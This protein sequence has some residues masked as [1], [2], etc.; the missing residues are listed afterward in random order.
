M[1]T[2][3]SD[4]SSTA[5]G[6]RGRGRQVAGLAMGCVVALA[7]GWIAAYAPGRIKLLGL[8]SLGWGALAGWCLGSL[9]R[10]L[11]IARPRTI[12][13]L[14]ALLI[15]GGFLAY[16]A[17]SYRLYRRN[18]QAQ[19]DRNPASQWKLEEQV[20]GG[21]TAEDRELRKRFAEEL[22][23]VGDL[24]REKLGP[25]EFLRSRVVQ[26]GRWPHPWPL[27]LWIGELL[28]S[29]I[30]GGWVAGRVIRRASFRLEGIR[31]LNCPLL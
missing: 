19:F 27:V 29:A 2:G 23:R 5:G 8:F 1:G 21:T 17:E 12:L 6:S 24:R 18:L 20:K 22:Q 7:L 31:S 25:A 30:L 3:M 4:S 15:A 16:S 11:Q 10:R 14:S 26:A 9:A 28:G 13:C